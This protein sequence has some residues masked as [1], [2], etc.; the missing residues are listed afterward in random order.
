MCRD[1]QRREKHPGVKLRPDD[2]DDRQKPGEPGAPA[3]DLA[4]D[5]NRRAD[6]GEGDQMRALDHA[7]LHGQGGQDA[8]GGG[9]QLADA[10]A[11]DRAVHERDRRDDEMVLKITIAGSPPNLY[12]ND[13]VTWNSQDRSFSGWLG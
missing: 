11:P 12:S 2:G 6:A 3:L 5:E 1:Q 4:E 7:L 13:T 10:R 9:W 8:G